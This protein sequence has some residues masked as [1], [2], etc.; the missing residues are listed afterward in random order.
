MS[1]FSICIRYRRAGV[2]PTLENTMMTTTAID[3]KDKSTNRDVTIPQVLGDRKAIDWFILDMRD[4][5]PE[6]QRQSALQKLSRDCPHGDKCT[7]DHAIR[8]SWT[9]CFKITRDGCLC[10]EHGYSA[11]RSTSL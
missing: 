9:W 1:R 8:I 6:H 3:F 5:T 11:Y 7:A 10:E 4:D 2:A